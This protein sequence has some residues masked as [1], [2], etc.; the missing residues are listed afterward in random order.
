MT[1][2]QSLN[3]PI[4]HLDYVTP[5]FDE[6]LM[7]SEVW[8]FPVTNKNIDGIEILKQEYGLWSDVVKQNNLGRVFGTDQSKVT[9]I[10]E[11]IEQNGVDP[12]TPPVFVDIE[13]GDI[14]TGGHRHDASGMLSIPGWMFQYVRCKN[15]WARKRFAK[16]LNNERVFHATL[17]NRDEVTEHIKYGI[18]HNEITCQKD[19]ED[20]IKLIAN[21]SL[22]VTVQGTL[23]KEMVSYISS[24]GITTVKLER[25]TSHNETTYQEF[26]DRSSDPYVKDVLNNPNV[27]NQYINMDNW[28]SRINSLIT[29]AAKTPLDS[30]LN[31]QASVA[32]P[33]KV[34]SLSVK[35]EKVH[36]TYFQNL[37]DNLDKLFTYKIKNGC[38]AFQHPKCTHAFLA[39]DHLDEGVQEGQFVKKSS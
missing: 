8:S 7:D 22:S 34:E 38:Y 32:L 31:I 27:R 36:G 9:Q 16:A 26:V 1:I 29:E 35:R 23:V 3:L 17:N 21:N 28:S 20:E 33:S 24:N 25:F 19:I 2:S 4:N 39:Q 14:I 15:H 18:K 11:D 12:S 13:T 6:K 37:A 10:K 5:Y 30:W